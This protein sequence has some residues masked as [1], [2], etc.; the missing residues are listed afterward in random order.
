MV[1]QSFV[2][3]GSK[4]NQRMERFAAVAIAI[5][6][7]L[8]NDLLIMLP[9]FF[10]HGRTKQRSLSLL[11]ES[12]EI[13]AR[14]DITKE[15]VTSGG[16]SN[17]SLYSNF[18]PPLDGLHTVLEVTNVSLS[19]LEILTTFQT[20]KTP[21]AFLS[22]SSLGLADAIITNY[23]VSKSN[24]RNIFFNHSSKRGDQSTDITGHT[25][26][27]QIISFPDMDMIN[28]DVN[29]EEVEE[30][31][32]TEEETEDGNSFD[33]DDD[34]SSRVMDYE[35]KEDEGVQAAAVASLQSAAT[36]TVSLSKP[37]L[38]YPSMKVVR[39]LVDASLGLRL[40]NSYRLAYQKGMIRVPKV[41]RH[42]PSYDEDNEDDDDF[43]DDDEH[44]GDKKDPG[45]GDD[46]NKNKNKTKNDGK[47]NREL[48]REP[49]H[50]VRVSGSI[51]GWHDINSGPGK[52]SS[53]YLQAILPLH[54]VSAVAVH[55]GQ[56]SLYGVAFTSLHTLGNNN[57]MVSMV[58]GVT[59]LPPGGLW[60]SLALF[61]IGYDPQSIIEFETTRSEESKL[62]RKIQKLEVKAARKVEKLKK[63]KKKSRKLLNEMM[64]LQVG[65]NIGNY[66]FTPCHT[67]RRHIEN[68]GAVCIKRDD[69]LISLINGIFKD[70]TDVDR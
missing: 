7:K 61:C 13:S 28:G 5:T 37:A 32:E 38:T 48:D 57:R 21:T 10:D 50:E 29:E 6:N 14:K 41:A 67:V 3:E 35:G 15:H 49:A 69:N 59:L 16:K 27:S 63:N 17:G 33:E 64:A 12:E 46:K 47:N 65:P 20:Q 4:G 44:S 58:D 8:Y 34:E 18:S 56:E 42:S 23:R 1:T 22:I 2:A 68:L 39:E 52:R 30:E 66:D 55:Q 11:S 19:E 60:I 45:D 51:R 70:W 62:E 26:L 36:V 54:S 53:S 40:M 31:E 43:S 24:L 25:T 9:S